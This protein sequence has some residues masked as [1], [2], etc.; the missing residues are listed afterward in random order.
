MQNK[1]KIQGD[2]F[3]KLKNMIVPLKTE[4]LAI[5][6]KYMYQ[7]WH[8]KARELMLD[9]FVFFFSKSYLSLHACKQYGPSPDLISV[10]LIFFPIDYYD[11]CNFYN[12]WVQVC[13]PLNIWYKLAHVNLECIIRLM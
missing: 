9:Y 12:I 10:Y 13:N 1:R 2:T 6:T 7:N 3:G 4:C 8:E 11:I 5:W